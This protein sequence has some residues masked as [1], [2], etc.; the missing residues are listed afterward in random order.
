MADCIFTEDLQQFVAAVVGHVGAAG[1]VDPEP[2]R[3]P[4]LILAIARG[5]VLKDGRAVR[6]DGVLPVFR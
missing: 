6:N 5:D 3:P 1:V 2:E 4:R